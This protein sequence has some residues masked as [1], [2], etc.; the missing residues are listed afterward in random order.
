[1][2]LYDDIWSTPNINSGVN[3]ITLRH[4]KISLFQVNIHAVIKKTLKQVVRDPSIKK[5]NQEDK[6]D[7][8][9]KELTFPIQRKSVWNAQLDSI[10]PNLSNKISL[11]KKQTEKHTKHQNILVESQINKKNDRHGLKSHSKAWFGEK[12]LVAVVLC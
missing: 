7:S 8:I 3:N 12:C 6:Y 9:R 11:N 1:M 10:Q 4:I 5:L 2:S